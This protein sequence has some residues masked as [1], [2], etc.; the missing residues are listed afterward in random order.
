MKKI[1]IGVSDFKELRENN[2]AYVDKSLFIKDFIEDSSKVVLITRPRRFGKTLNLNML[3]TFFEVGED[4]AYLFEDLNIYR[5]KEIMKNTG[6]F[7]VIALTFKDNKEKHLESCLEKFRSMVAAE[8]TKYNFIIDAKVLEENEVIYFKNIK[9]KKSSI[10]ELQE[11]IY[12]LTVF[13]YRAYKVKPILLIDEYDTPIQAAYMNGYYDNFIDFMRSFLGSALKD[14]PS[15]E[16]A[17]LTGILRVAKE[18]IFSGLNN[19]SVYSVINNEY[20]E[21]FGFLQPEVDNLFTETNTHYC[22]EEVKSWYNGYIFGQQEIYNPWSIINYIKKE[23]YGF[24]P[25]WVNSS[26]NL[27]IK[28]ILRSGNEVLKMEL[29]ELITGKTLRKIIDDNIVFN[30]ITLSSQNVWNFLLFSGYLKAVSKSLVNG[31]LFCD[32]CIP[33]GE[34]K[35]IYEDVIKAW[36][37]IGTGTIEYP[38]LLNYLVNGEIDGF[39]KLFPKLVYASFSYFDVTYSESEKFYHAFVLG[40]L[41]YLEDY[42]VKSNR[43]SGYGRYDVCII[44]KDC[45]K[46]GVIIEFKRGDV[47][48]NL[49]EI[50][51][52]ALKQIGYKNYRAELIEL[53]VMECNIVEIGIGFIGKS[54]MVVVK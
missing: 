24:S 16:K 33:N 36:F 49:E 10:V 42:Y 13:I 8:Y 17:L 20:S 12:K 46:R 54:S 19:L 45:T 29:E 25:Y 23:S 1:S 9:A 52:S 43:E 44:P 14:N 27:I 38:T 30:E 31:R 26:D 35:V 22:K 48:D 2:Y 7:P 15:I 37:Q 51:R 4:N 47:G 50:T 40:M 53:G 21:Y 34:V 28:D 39:I 5:F 6:K 11:S 41:V 32:L 18:S 3:K